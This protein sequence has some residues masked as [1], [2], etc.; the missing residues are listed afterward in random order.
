MYYI[1]CFTFRTIDPTER[2]GGKNDER[3]KEWKK[4]AEEKLK[5]QQIEV[6]SLI[7]IRDPK[8]ALKRA[9]IVA[10]KGVPGLDRIR[11]RLERGG[12]LIEIKKTDAVLLLDVDLETDPYNPDDD[13]VEAMVDSRDRVEKSKTDKEREGSSTSSSLKRSSGEQDDANVKLHH[14]IG[15]SSGRNGGEVSRDDNRPAREDHRRDRYL[16]GAVVDVNYIIN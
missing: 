4:T 2:K 6:G 9:K 11:V 5:K 10:V 16:Q 13:A 15:R 7:W 12:R 8:Y 3:V 14:S 1:P